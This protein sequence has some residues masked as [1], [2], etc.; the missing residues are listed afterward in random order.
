MG[1]THEILEV[2]LILILFHRWICLDMIPMFATFRGNLK[3]R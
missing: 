2:L 3:H 1:E